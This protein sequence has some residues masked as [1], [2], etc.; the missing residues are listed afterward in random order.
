M[1]NSI[2]EAY[3]ATGEVIVFPNPNQGQFS[4]SLGEESHGDVI[5]YLYNSLGQLVYM[6]ESAAVQLEQE[7]IEVQHLSRGIY[8]LLIKTDQKL[9][10]G[11]VVIE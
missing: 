11:S 6:K 10:R 5:V 7:K 2:G 3:T 8:Q 1:Q 4:I 9:Y